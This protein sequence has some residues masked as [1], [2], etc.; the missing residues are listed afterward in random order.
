MTKKKVK[1]KAKAKVVLKKRGAPTKYK[2]EYCQDIIA[3]FNDDQIRIVEDKN[4]KPI[5]RLTFPTYA[6]YAAKI[7][8][9]KDTLI[10]WSNVHKEFSDAYKKAK[11]I[12]ENNLVAGAMNGLYNPAFSIFF[13]K[14]NL[15]Y[16]N[17]PLPEDKKESLKREHSKKLYEAIKKEI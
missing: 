10:E 8:V 12:Q 11:S 2:P 5:L 13:A 1:T 9:D 7:D 3:Y 15:G 17:E 16:R 6:G 4:G 14:N